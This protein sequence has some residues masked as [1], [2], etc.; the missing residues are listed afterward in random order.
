MRRQSERHIHRGSGIGA[1]GAGTMLSKGVSKE[2][3][4]HTLLVLS[5]SR[6]RVTVRP[7]WFH[8]PISSL[9]LPAPTPFQLWKEAFQPTRTE[10]HRLWAI[11][12][13]ASRHPINPQRRMLRGTLYVLSLSPDFHL[14][15][16][17]RRRYDHR[18]TCKTRG[19]RSTVGKVRTAR[20]S[21]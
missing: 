10:V 6:T 13:G 14:T 17:Q 20:I 12:V 5:D 2:P 16:H 15:V 4:T 19:W 1:K 3:C 18:R 9:N 7:S 21:C 11:I 8:L